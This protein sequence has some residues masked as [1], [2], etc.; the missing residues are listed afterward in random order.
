MNSQNRSIYEFGVYRLDPVER[1]LTREG[2]A[3]P[4]PP[5][6]FEALVML[7]ERGGHLVGREELM[8]M[9]WADSFV[10]DA[11][12]SVQISTL[13]KILNQNGD[14]AQFIETVPR[15]SA[16]VSSRRLERLKM[17]IW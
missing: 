8:Q 3:V 1:L 2:A 6:A 13:R 10:E 11:N 16:I 17:T 4:V 15:V 14:A 5:K 7:V 12:L 9:L